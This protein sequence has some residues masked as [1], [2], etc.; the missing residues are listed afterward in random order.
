M[1]PTFLRPARILCL[2]TSAA[3][4]TGVVTA[5]TPPPLRATAAAA[6]GASDARPGELVIHRT[7]NLDD[8]P[9]G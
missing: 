8:D 6:A 3:L 5:I 7:R 9:Q 2:V 1:A 4:V